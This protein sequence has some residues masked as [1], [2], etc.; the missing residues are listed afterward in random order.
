[1]TTL[2]PGEEIALQ[3]AG[4]CF[5]THKETDSARFHLDQEAFDFRRDGDFIWLTRKSDSQKFL[6][7]KNNFLRVVQNV[8]VS[9]ETASTDPYEYIML[10]SVIN[11]DMFLFHKDQLFKVEQVNL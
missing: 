5:I 9:Q 8:P 1:M 6:I 11:D 4:W 10:Q 2:K 3:D 7:Y